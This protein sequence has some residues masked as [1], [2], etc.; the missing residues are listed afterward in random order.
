MKKL[1]FLIIFLSACGGSEVTE[2]PTTTTTSPKETTTTSSSTTTTVKETATTIG[3]VGKPPLNPDLVETFIPDN[4]E[5][6]EYTLKGYLH[7]YSYSQRGI[8]GS[9]YGISFYTGIWSTFEE[10]LPLNFQR[11]HGT[12]LTPDNSDTEEPLCRRGTVARE[13]CGLA[14]EA[15]AFVI[16]WLRL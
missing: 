14:G 5:I 2:E 6:D 8:K 13:V 15:R 12:W 11:G 10:Y 16:P 9:N 3:N 4:A 1:I 7:A